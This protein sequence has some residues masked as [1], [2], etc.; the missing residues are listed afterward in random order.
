MLSKI[1][2]LLSLF[3]WNIGF[4]KYEKELVN[5]YYDSSS[6]NNSLCKQGIIVMID[7]RQIHGGFADRIRG[8]ATIYQFCKNFNVPFSVYYDYPFKLEDFLEPV[9]F[10]WVCKKT[11]L[12]YSKK[13]A[14]PVLLEEWMFPHKYHKLYL[15]L[16]VLFSKKIQLHVYTN[17]HFYYDKFSEQFNE[18]FKPT[19]RLQQSIEWNLKNIGSDYVAMVFRFQQLLG[20]FKEGDF[21]VLS[22]TDQS[23]LIVKCIKEIEKKWNGKDKVLVTSD[24][25]RFLSEVSKLS[26]VYTIPGQVVHID[27][28]KDA[29]FETYMKSFVDFYMLSKAKEVYLLLTDDMFQSG[30]PKTAS[31]VH[32]RPFKIIKF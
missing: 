5:K 2:Q 6:E 27:Y 11:E 30:F 13:Q 29:T 12:S 7:G 15:L 1:K 17:S 32:N 14:K 3:V 22:E 23:K 18:L 20:D 8:I 16:N 31:K 9:S 26:F 28:T 4:H 24:S 21:K 25:S 10:N 19:L